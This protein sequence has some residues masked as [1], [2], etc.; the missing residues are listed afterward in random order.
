MG[1]IIVAISLADAS[2]CPQGTTVPQGDPQER[3]GKII[4]SG[5]QEPSEKVYL[6]FASSWDVKKIWVQVP[7]AHSSTTSP[8]SWPRRQ[9]SSILEM[10][11]DEELLNE[12][13]GPRWTCLIFVGFWSLIS[14]YLIFGMINLREACLSIF[15]L[16]FP[17]WLAA[18]ASERS[19]LDPLKL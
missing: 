8:S 7:Q 9:A 5:C 17:P 19:P 13:H 16:S 11:S 3:Y 15:L 12:A 2:S 6:P 4:L 10:L 1:T 14:S 18:C